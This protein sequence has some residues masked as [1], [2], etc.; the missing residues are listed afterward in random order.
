MRHTYRAKVYSDGSMNVPVAVMEDKGIE[1]NDEVRVTFPD[2][3]DNDTTLSF[4]RY[5][6]SDM[7][8]TVPKD[9]RTLF[10]LCDEMVTIEMVLTG[11]SWER[12]HPTDTRGGN[13]TDV[14]AVE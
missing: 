13:R 11:D 14:K 10:G 1:Y 12:E 4:T 3:G 8:L 9:I 7:C 5:V 2:F 6:R